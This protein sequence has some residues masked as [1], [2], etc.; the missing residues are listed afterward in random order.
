M[1]KRY[2]PPS[3][4]SGSRSL[5]AS[6][7]SGGGGSRRG[8]AFKNK[9]EDH[10]YCVVLHV[11]EAINFCGRDGEN[12]Q[13]VM[14]AALNTVDFEIEGRPSATSETIIFNSN[15]IWE[16]DMAGIKRIKTDHRPVKVTFYSCG[17]Q[18]ERKSIGTLVLP[19]RGLPVISSMGNQ[20]ALQLKM[21]WHKLI[22][23]SN[24][25]RSHKPE[26]LLMLAI[27]KKSLLQTKDF[28]H[29]M[30]FDTKSPASSPLQSPGHSITANMLHSQA[31]VY[32]QSL[33]QLGLLQVGNDPLIDCDII[34]VVLQLK[35]LKNICKLVKSLNNGKNVGTVLLVFDF[36]GNVTNIELKLNEKDSYVLNDVL[37]L[38]FKSSLRSMRLY[39]QRIFYLPINMYINGT[40]VAN[41]RMDFG[42]LMPLDSYFDTNRKYVHNGSFTFN[43]LGRADS[44]R[45]LRPLIEYTFSVDIKSICSRQSQQGQYEDDLQP[46]IS[47]VSSVIR[48]LPLEHQDQKPGTTSWQHQDDSSAASLNVGAELSASENEDLELPLDANTNSEEAPK[49][50]R[51]NQKRRKKF[52]RVTTKEES[53]D[54]EEDLCLVN[55][56]SS[57]VV[58]QPLIAGRQDY[59]E[60]T[61]ST[62]EDDVMALYS[63]KDFN[64]GSGES[65]K[66]QAELKSRES[67]AKLERQKTTMSEDKA[68]LDKEMV[69]EQINK[70]K[71]KPVKKVKTDKCKLHSAWDDLQNEIEISKKSKK[72]QKIKSELLRGYAPKES[73]QDDF[74]M[75]GKS[76]KSK[77]IQPIVEN[78]EYEVDMLEQI[79]KVKVKPKPNLMTSQSEAKVLRNA[80]KLEEINAADLQELPQMESILARKERMRKRQEIMCQKSNRITERD[81]DEP[82]A[83]SENSFA[84]IPSRC[85]RSVQR[86]ESSMDFFKREVISELKSKTSDE[87]SLLPHTDTSD[88]N[89]KESVHLTVGPKESKRKLKPQL[90]ANEDRCKAPLTAKESR[91]V[92]RAPKSEMALSA[93]WVE[94]NRHQEKLIK[95]NENYIEQMYKTN[96]MIEK[97]RI[98]RTKVRPT[99]DNDNNMEDSL[100]SDRV[101]TTKSRQAILGDEQDQNHSCSQ[102]SSK[103]YIASQSTITNFLSTSAE[104]D[105][106]DLFENKAIKQIVRKKSVRKSEIEIENPNSSL[107]LS[108]SLTS[109]SLNVSIKKKLSRKNSRTDPLE[110]LSNQ[111][112]FKDDQRKKITKKSSESAV[113]EDSTH[114]D[115]DIWKKQQMALFEKELQ[116]KID[117]LRLE[118]FQGEPPPQSDPKYESKFMELEKHVVTLKQEMEEQVDFFRKRNQEI[119]DENT[120]LHAKKAQ[121]EEQVSRMEYEIQQLSQRRNV[122]EV[123]H[124]MKQLL[125]ELA[126]QN[127][128]IIDLSKEKERFKRQWRRS[129]KKMHA[130]KLSMLEKNLD[131]NQGQ[132]NSESIGMINLRSILTKDAVEFEREYGQFRHSRSIP[133]FQIS[134]ESDEFTSL[135][136]RETML[137]KSSQR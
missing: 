58:R 117:Q 26:V 35:Q 137:T 136:S 55:K 100:A 120:R 12:E 27:V 15:C 123:G 49:D 59:S 67:N 73:L 69:K 101:K 45:E 30:Q 57:M 17:S 10:I 63:N 124:D 37:G 47:S 103:E 82:T 129:A 91:R 46:S 127:K 60:L 81:E 2:K 38:R 133:S 7:N 64:K 51:Q 115:M 44:A 5:A 11:V 16:C 65:G 96:E 54:S 28:E 48:E 24:E 97:K 131:Y 77:N 95:E 50:V 70:T 20:T 98:K 107:E 72:L 102:E 52:T 89:L 108:E 88:P 94:V 113:C 41:Y 62:S 78:F 71:M 13:I 29:L 33:V 36:V 23:I 86:T 109:N 66:Q 116:F 84:Y 43:R 42:K 6:E 22:C 21:F 93:R 75:R 56:F 135:A 118:E 92:P 119:T 18:Q 25:F 128:R 8:D 1:V 134:T 114:V 4:V 19:V 130:L 105:E 106:E 79:K 14:N 85:T 74:P 3:S 90:L 83:E 76:N 110:Q 80:R 53:P 39:F 111:E 121:L 99:N 87:Q 61:T 122:L 125:N 68:E 31:N 126:K 34:E 112:S 132:N 9:D 104:V 40:A 32:V